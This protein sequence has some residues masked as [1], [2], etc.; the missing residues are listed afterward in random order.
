MILK[1][2][3][4]QKKISASYGH[5]RMCKY[6]VGDLYCLLHNHIESFLKYNKL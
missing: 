6:E 2:P 1:F 4:I 5:N 3:V